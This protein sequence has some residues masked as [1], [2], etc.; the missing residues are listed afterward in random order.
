MFIVLIRTTLIDPKF[1][2]N[3]DSFCKTGGASISLGIDDLL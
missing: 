2:A 1:I 3:E